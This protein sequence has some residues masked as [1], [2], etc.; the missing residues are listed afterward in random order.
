MIGLG[1][2]ITNKYRSLQLHSHGQIGSVYIAN[3]LAPYAVTI[4]Q[5]TPITAAG[6]QEAF[7]N[8]TDNNSSI[9]LRIWN[10]DG[11]LFFS[12][13]PE[14]TAA[15]H[16][17]DDLRA[18]LEGR[19][20]AK[21]ER[22][23]PQKPDF[24]MTY[25][26]FEVY[27]PIYDPATGEMVAAGEVYQDA[28][29]ILQDRAFVERMIWAALA[30]VTLC[31]LAMLALSFSQSAQLQDRL[32]AERRMR[33]QNTALRRAA[34]QARLDAAQAN[35]QVLNLIG[36]ELHDG[37]VQLLGLISLLEGSD[38]K[39][40][41]ADGTT[42]RGLIDQ[43]MTELRAMSAGLIL[44]EL[45]ELDSTGVVGLA[46][47]RH[48]ALTGQAVDLETEGPA[49]S[50]DAP[51]RICL[52]RVVQ[53]GLTNAM[54]HGGDKTPKVVITSQETR[55]VISI[56]NGASSDVQETPRPAAWRLGLNGMRR[57]LDAFGGELVLENGGE[58]AMLRVTLPIGP[59]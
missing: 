16:Q 14:D 54:R 8:L 21:L 4:Q 30:F 34:D 27:A 10:L 37:P 7:R 59:A 13:F 5:D 3:L 42:L 15:E 58:T 35:E 24:P 48:K 18:A 38:R 11:S 31:V 43:V 29:E 57:R 32:A 39:T 49:V 55:L 56:H 20:V 41:L 6:M 9:M 40:E 44:P 46:V 19:F 25:P 17:D 23:G 22:E 52:Y 1:V 36:A 53:E 45:D 33:K 2:F 51:R 12:T 28:T 26:Y 47:H 50:L